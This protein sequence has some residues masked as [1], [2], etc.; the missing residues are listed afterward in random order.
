M[1]N[2]V[3]VYKIHNLEGEEALRYVAQPKG[4]RYTVENEVLACVF[5]CRAGIKSIFQQREGLLSNAPTPSETV[6]NWRIGQGYLRVQAATFVG[7]VRPRLH[8]KL[9][10]DNVQDGEAQHRRQALKYILR[11]RSDIRKVGSHEASYIPRMGQKG[12]NGRNS[13]RPSDH[14]L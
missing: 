3:V 2:S 1:S 14:I 8:P 10:L 7:V 13:F 6:I 5:D 11:F 12:L 4:T 9:V